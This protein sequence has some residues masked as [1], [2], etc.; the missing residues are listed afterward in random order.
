VSDT[1]AER[2]ALAVGDQI[3]LPAPLRPLRVTVAGV[4]PDYALDLGSIK[5]GW[6]AF[7]AHFGEQGAN[8]L[9][10]EVAPGVSTQAMKRRIEATTA[11]RYDV[12]ILTS[13]ELQAIID[14]LI[15]Q[16]F[17]LTYWLQMLAVVV[18]VLAMVNATSATVIDRSADLATLRALGL[19]RRRLVR[20]LV[21]EAGLLGV[22]SGVLGVGA[23]ALVGA[24]LVRVVAPAIAGFRMVLQWS[25]ISLA[26]LVGVTTV[27]A[28]ASAFVVA[29]S[30]TRRPIAAGERPT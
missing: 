5:L 15:D 29:R 4:A 8:I 18:T 2:Y 27:A 28:A 17:A 11:G 13:S 16:S 1:L 14:Q 21:M 23:G 26:T 3:E 19:E 9:G 10:L 24:T 12:S 30:Q 6:T 25:P 22:L 7:R 20:L